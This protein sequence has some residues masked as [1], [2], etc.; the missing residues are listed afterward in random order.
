ME[1]SPIAPLLPAEV[2]ARCQAL[3]LKPDPVELEGRTVRLAPLDPARDTPALFALTNGQPARL[4][5]RAVDTYDADTRI[6]R[7]MN[8]GPYPDVTSMAAN[9]AGWCSVA[10]VLCLC[11]YDRATG[12]PVGSASYMS[13]HPAHLKI[14]LGSIWYSPLAQGTAANTE[15]T[16]LMLRHAFDLGYR[17]VEWKCNALNTRSRR[18]ALRLGFQFEG[19]QEYHFITKGRNRDT[20]WF[21]MLDKE[22]PAVRAHLEQT[23]HDW[24]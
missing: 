2:L 1:E 19:I 5:T 11:V 23:L 18:A 20:A 24:V 4:G 10:D 17:R 13:N 16:Y 15:A 3:P 7:Y 21:R 9:L 14:E 22:W 12:T 6:W 8:S